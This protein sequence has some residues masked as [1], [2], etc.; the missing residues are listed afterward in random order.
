M[1]MNPDDIRARA[2]GVGLD[3]LLHG[4]N[5]ISVKGKEFLMNCWGDFQAAL[6]VIEAEERRQA[7]PTC[8]QYRELGAEIGMV[9][10]LGSKTCVKCHDC[11]GTGKKV[12]DD[13]GNIIRNMGTLLDVACG[14]IC[15]RD[16]LCDLCGS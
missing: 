5:T 12:M 6:D 7:C 16:L 11:K 1:P 4:K 3:V 15:P 13:D 8:W 2:Q 9:S 14:D 10:V